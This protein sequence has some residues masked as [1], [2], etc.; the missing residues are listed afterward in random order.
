MERMSLPTIPLLTGSNYQ[1]W[2]MKMEAILIIRKLKRALI[3]EKPKD[4]AEIKEKIDW[5]MR[6]QDTVAYIRLHLSYVLGYT[7]K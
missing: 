3:E 4:A 6:N 5:E 7:R 1:V 2:A